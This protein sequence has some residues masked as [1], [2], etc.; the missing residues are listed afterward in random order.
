PTSPPNTLRRARRTRRVGAGGRG[1]GGIHDLVQSALDGRLIG[2]SDLVEYVADLVRPAALHR[3]AVKDTWQDSEQA[4][5]AIDADHVEPF[6]GAP[7]A[8]EI[9]EESIRRRF[10]SPP[11]G[12]R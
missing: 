5:A 2:F 4:G 12:R 8:A 11:G 6:A 9:G 1:V 3:D 10:R 7:A